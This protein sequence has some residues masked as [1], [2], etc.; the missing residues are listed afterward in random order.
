MNAEK[1]SNLVG[2]I[3]IALGLFALGWMAFKSLPVLL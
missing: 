3:G 2:R 1:L